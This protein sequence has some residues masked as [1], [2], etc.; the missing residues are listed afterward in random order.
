MIIY[1]KKKV[2]HLLF[3][4]LIVRTKSARFMKHFISPNYR[5][6][7]LLLCLMCYNVGQAQSV[8]FDLKTSPSIVFDFNSIDGFEN[9]I[10]RLNVC[11]LNV[12]VVGVQWDL[13]IRPTT[14]VPGFWDVVATYTPTVNVPPISILE[15]R[16]R[17]ASNTT[18]VGGFFPLQELLA[19]YY[20]I[21]SAAAPDPLVACPNVGTNQPGDYM[22]SPGCYRFTVD[23]RLNPGFVYQLG[24]YT[25]RIDYVL[26]E[27]L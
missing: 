21:G 14:T 12:N 20:I 16:I 24:L 6:I 18:Q 1:N 2:N 7:L 27:D 4:I 5:A 10:T 11:E 3:V 17:N 9:G 8:S 26:V 15:L 19:P 13:Y 25:L 23:L 22:N